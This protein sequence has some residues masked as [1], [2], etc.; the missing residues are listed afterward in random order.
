MKEI[1]KSTVFI[2]RED[3]LICRFFND[4]ENT[5]P[6]SH[7]QEIVLFK[8][9]ENGNM[10]AAEEIINANLRFVVFVAKHYTGNGLDLIDLI[11]A[12][13]I[14][15]IKSARSGIYD[16]RL[17]YRFISYA[18]R[19]IQLS[20][21]AE[22]ARSGRPIRIPANQ[23]WGFWRIKKSLE[24]AEVDDDY[25]TMMSTFEREESLLPSRPLLSLDEP[26]R[27]EEESSLYDVIPNNGE[28]GSDCLVMDDT[29]KNTVEGIL[30]KMNPRVAEI[31]RLRF[32]LKDGIEYS[33]EALAHQF[34]VTKGRINALISTARWKNLHDPDF[35]H[36]WYGF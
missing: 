26:Y 6:L 28:V 30:K 20:I 31:Y 34:G 29:N 33:T 22:I 21:L 24:R 16:Y 36:L 32:G 4:I 14:G 19:A 7:A 11:N 13:N 27:G 8:A 10:L 1:V 3:P 12:G 25:V 17:G 15:L 18:V 5:Q 23:L 2:G 35:K 9:F